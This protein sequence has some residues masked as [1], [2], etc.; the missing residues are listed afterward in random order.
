[1]NI[2]LIPAALCFV[3]QVSIDL[4]SWEFAVLTVDDSNITG[5]PKV[6]KLIQQI[7][8]LP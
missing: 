8:V 5:P 6:E 1:M 2:A 4:L 3:V 7:T